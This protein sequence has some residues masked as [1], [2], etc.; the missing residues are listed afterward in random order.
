[1]GETPTVH[2]GLG[3]GRL[4]FHRVVGPFF[5]AKRVLSALSVPMFRINFLFYYE[6]RKSE[7]TS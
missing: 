2:R 7:L 5:A 4:D 1:M 3:G 6:K